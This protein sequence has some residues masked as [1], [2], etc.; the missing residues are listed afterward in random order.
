V[1][2][3][4]D[5]APGAL[6]RELQLQRIL[7]DLSIITLMAS[8]NSVR[9]GTSNDPDFTTDCVVVG[10]G[11]AGGSLAAFLASNGNKHPPSFEW[12]LWG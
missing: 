4:L 11:P 10:S 1:R 8:S 2:F 12:R 9:T 6:G 3:F 5:K 7:S